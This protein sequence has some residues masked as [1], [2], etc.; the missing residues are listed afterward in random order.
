MPFGDGLR[1]VIQL[2][3][4]GAT[5]AKTAKQIRKDIGDVGF[6][7]WVRRWRDGEVWV[8]AEYASEARRDALSSRLKDAGYTVRHIGKPGTSGE[9]V[10]DITG[11]PVGQNMAAHALLPRAFYLDH[12]ERD[13][14]TPEEVNRNR[15]H[16]VVRTDD[17]HLED[18]LQ[19]ALFYSSPDGPDQ[20]PP[21]LKTSAKATVAAINKARSR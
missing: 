1:A 8:G 18:L 9:Y 14:P 7:F 4:K 15:T 10:I 6:K 2:H 13:L 11:E 20:L 16:I 19:D 3:P 17:P 21:G 5:M 12:L